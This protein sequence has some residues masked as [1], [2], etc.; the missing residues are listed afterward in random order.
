[1]GRCSGTIC[2]SA[3]VRKEKEG[4]TD[5]ILLL[6]RSRKKKGINEIRWKKQ[7]RAPSRRSDPVPEGEERRRIHSTPLRILDKKEDESLLD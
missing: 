7:E 4:R 5:L 1:M 6:S 2:R 3:A